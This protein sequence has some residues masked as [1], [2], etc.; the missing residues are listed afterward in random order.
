MSPVHGGDI[1]DAYQIQTET[2]PYFLK[3]NSVDYAETMFKA[4]ALGLRLISESGAIAAPHVLTTGKIGNHAYLILEFIRS[5]SKTADAMASFGRQL[6][7]MHSANHIQFG[8]ETD[9][10]IGR[11]PQSN[12]RHD[13]WV[14]F[15][16]NERLMPQFKMALDDNLMTISDV[17]SLHLLE[18]RLQSL[19]PEVN[20]SLL[21]GDL[22][23]GNYLIDQKGKPYLIDPAVYYGHSEVDIA[24][25]RLFGG[26]SSAFYEA[27]F[28]ILPQEKY[29]NE[30]MDIYQ[31]YYLLVH[32]NLFG[33]SYYDS[34]RSIIRKYF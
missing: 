23:G 24:M 31:L 26:F 8:L 32:L 2:K 12:Q 19:M 11:L 5:G 34:V 33:S 10:F 27:Y 22:W 14:S 18:S 9:N 17:P 4:E 13:D 28:E 29:F 20:A 1:S 7:L 6:A 3:L 25:S 30:R 15:Y 16:I 21:H